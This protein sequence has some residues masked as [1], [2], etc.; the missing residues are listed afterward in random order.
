M[1]EPIPCL[2]AFYGAREESRKNIAKSMIGPGD[3]PQEIYTPLP[4]II[5]LLQVWPKIALDPCSGPD[6]LVPAET[7]WCVPPR[8]E[9]K[10]TVF[11]AQDNEVDGLC[12]PWQDY[13]YVNPPYADLK[14][15]LAKCKEQGQTYEVATLVPTRGHRRWFRK[16]A[17]SAALVVDLDPVKFV[18]YKST[19]PAP[20]CLLYWGECANMMTVAFEA[21]GDPRK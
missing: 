20:L 15:W 17:L 12:E 1:P 2:Q 18:G 13:T 21:L 10:R 7:K 8:K 6:S 11:I 9:G 14:V 16:A 19:F 4:I 3:R 5:A